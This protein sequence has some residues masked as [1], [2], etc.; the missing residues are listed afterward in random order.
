MPINVSTA[1]ELTTAIQ[2]AKAG[3]EIVLA[4]G[5]YAL[6]NVNCTASATSASPIV[7]RSA[8]PLAARVDFN[9]LE[10]FK[11]SGAHWHFE[12]L[13]VHGV[14]ANDADCEHAFHV[15]G[16]AVG[17]V[18]RGNRVVDFNAQLKVNASVSSPGNA[19]IPHQGLIEYNE[20]YDTHARNTT[21]PVTKLN[22]DTGDDW[23]VRGNYI[24][25]FHK[26]GSG[27]VTYGAFLKSG[28]KR[29]LVERNL[30]VC[31]K[32]VTSST[33]TIGL[34]FGGGGTGNA[35]CA[36]AFNASVACAIEHEDGVM[37]NNV[38]A[39]CADVGVYLNRAKNSKIQF[40]TLIATSGIDFRFDTTS[41]EARGNVYTGQIRNREASTGTFADNLLRTANEFAAMYQAPL[42]GD[43]RLK[44]DVSALTGKI[45]GVTINDDYCGRPR[46]TAPFDLGALESS[47]GDC[48]TVPP[49]KGGAGAND[50]GADGSVPGS[51][52]GG[53]SSS[54]GASSGGASSSGGS[55]GTPTGNGNDDLAGDGCGCRTTRAPAAGFAAWIAASVLAFLILR[56]RR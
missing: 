2:N 5:T 22:I 56:R 20:L 40:N 16:G 1:A 47:L 30:V 37:Q 9:G 41:G 18:M 51:D 36:P 8:T 39:S 26:V 38:I 55:S 48:A 14:C 53:T 35:F 13:D 49:P 52:G 15:F 33:T 17:F 21:A 25:D 28:G 42:A 23:V 46:G 4:A 29:G 11:V 45:S 27:A 31:S 32:D 50:A 43:L 6:V 34:S 7:V 44:G 3:D 10:G 24:H 54:G 19:T 12:G